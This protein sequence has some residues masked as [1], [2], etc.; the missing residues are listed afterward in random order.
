MKLYDFYRIIPGAER[1]A[2]QFQKSGWNHLLKIVKVGSWVRKIPV[3]DLNYDWSWY[4]VLE[5]LDH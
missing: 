3:P 4:I 5:G 1:R 2:I